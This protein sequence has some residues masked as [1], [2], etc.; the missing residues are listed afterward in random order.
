MG[1]LFKSRQVIKVW[2]VETFDLS[3]LTG[4]DFTSLHCC[5]SFL[6]P[7]NTHTSGVRLSIWHA[8]GL[9]V[10]FLSCCAAAWMADWEQQVW[11]CKSEVS[12]FLSL[13]SLAAPLLQKYRIQLWEVQ[14][15]TGVALPFRRDLSLISGEGRGGWWGLNGD[16]NDGNEVFRS[17]EASIHLN[18]IQLVPVSPKWFSSLSH[19]LCVLECVFGHVQVHALW[20]NS[21][22]CCVDPVGCWLPLACY[23]GDPI[24]ESIIASWQG[25]RSSSES[26]ESMEGIAC[27]SAFFYTYVNIFQVFVADEEFG[28]EP[29]LSGTLFEISE[30]LI[31]FC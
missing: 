11:L 6:Y 1:S 25:W 28:L 23:H 8:L 15:A 13:L 2:G 14:F 22:R 26:T 31:F 27:Y 16:M 12:V 20:A 24:W 4:S 7:K 17:A 9:C 29:L 5:V 18:V 21:H 3:S 10:R 19:L 30:L